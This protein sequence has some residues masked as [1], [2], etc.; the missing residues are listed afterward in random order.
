MDFMSAGRGSL[1]TLSVTFLVMSKLHAGPKESEQ[2][3]EAVIVHDL[4]MHD[5]SIMHDSSAIIEHRSARVDRSV[6]VNK[7]L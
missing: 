4:C 6:C 7:R 1:D 5:V 3:H 2:S